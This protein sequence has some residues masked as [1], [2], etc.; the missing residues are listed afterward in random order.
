MLGKL[1]ERDL[2]VAIENEQPFASRL[3]QAVGEGRA[4]ALVDLVQQPDSAIALSDVVYDRGRAVGAAVVHNDYFNIRHDSDDVLEDVVECPFDIL[5]F[6]VGRNDHGQD[7]HEQHTKDTTGR[8]RA[9]RPPGNETPAIAAASDRAFEGSTTDT[10]VAITSLEKST[11]TLDSRKRLGRVLVVG[12][13]FSGAVIARKLA[14]AGLSC[15]VV[16]ERD[17]P[18]GN[19]HTS[20]DA[21]T[22]IMIH[23]YGPH[24]FHTDDDEIWAFVAKF[25]E[26]M[27]YRHSVFATV[28]GE[29]YSLPVNLLTINQFFRS[30]MVPAEAE[31]F[32]KTLQP[33]IAD[34]ANFREQALSMV[35]ERL[36]ETFFR[37]YTEKQW[38]V[39]PELLP[40]S[41][42]KRLPLRFSY[43]SNYF[44]HRQQAMPRDGYTA[45]VA[46]ILDHRNIEL[47]LGVASETLTETFDHTF[48][49]G[50][51]DR[52]FGY[53][54][55]DLG[56]RTLR[57]EEVRTTGDGLGCPVMNFP[58]P[59][60][61]WTRM[62]EHRHLSPW[63]NHRSPVSI[64][65]KEYAQSAVRGSALFYPL[66]LAADERLLEA[67][68]GLARQRPGVTFFGRLGS[69]AYIDMDAAIRRAIDTAAVAVRALTSG[70]SP[71]A[72]V[73]QPLGKA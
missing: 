67:Y 63:R 36:Y 26:W 25:G 7:R 71:P 57:F 10:E 54:L 34:P 59:G 37:H 2:A 72:F 50:G 9:M 16:D 41:I 3:L 39:E 22:G 35:G 6:I 69:Y 44:H 5:L 53:C 4:M 11:T 73:H 23:R 42:L 8:Q 27:P 46:A 48:Y 28:G 18:A 24:I 61:P 64:I 17:H 58:D 45:I 1:S 14:E 33:P 38:G 62:T 68:V 13:G 40:A 56:Y 70:N 52:Y 31:E 43:D 66:R 29:V 20:E 15:L 51:I 60:T 19:C 12:A 55:G 65:W 32:I 30:A 49:S 47:R 21:E